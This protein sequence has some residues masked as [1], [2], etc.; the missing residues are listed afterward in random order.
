VTERVCW[1]DGHLRPADEAAVRADDSA[2]SEGR[3]CYTSVRFRAGAPRFAER[4]V[5]RLQRAARALC[6]P[7]PDA[8][9]LHHALDEL[10]RAAFASGDGVVRL[11]LSRD[12]EGV[13]H[14][15]GVPRDLGDDRARWRAITAPF[16]HPG[17]PLPGGPKLTSRLL[18]SMAAEAARGADA[19]EAL[20]F[21]AAGRLVEGARSNVIVRHRDGATSTPP[22][23]RGAVAGVALEVMSER[24]PFL[25]RRDTSRRGLVGAAGVVVVNAVRG[26]RPLVDLDGEPLGAEGPSLAAE[27][28]ALW[29][30]T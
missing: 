6:L 18:I 15:V 24:M 14:V 5:E 10:G 22:V 21:D 17:A 12:E 23:E 4:H 1:V 29:E 27:L 26:V 28:N 2:F 16:P 25:R 7:A 11:Q 20:L 8:L 30:A 9:A 13:L 3:G 19:D